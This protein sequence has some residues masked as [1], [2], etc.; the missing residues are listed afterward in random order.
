MLKKGLSLLSATFCL[1]I[2]I[3]NFTACA[4]NPLPGNDD[5]VEEV[6]ERDHSSLESIVSY[7]LSL[8]ESTVYIKCNPVR[9]IGEFGEPMEFDDPEIE[10]LVHELA[11]KG[12][13]GITKA[14]DIIVF[15][16]WRQ[17]FDVEF[18]AG[19]GYSDDG[20]VDAYAVQFLTYQEPLSKENW[21]YYEED[22]NEWRARRTEK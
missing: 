2:I 17:H 16:V 5:G 15:D 8:E 12:Y 21:C 14:H 18:E 10:Q 1:L 3:L 9:I 22:Y 20:T 7:L 11:E 6:F 4:R 19:F 13:N